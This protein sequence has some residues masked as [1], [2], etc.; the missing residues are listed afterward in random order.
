MVG[1]LIDF[2]GPSQSEEIKTNNTINILNYI[3]YFHIVTDLFPK[4]IYENF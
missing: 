2:I 1:G 3:R 4:A